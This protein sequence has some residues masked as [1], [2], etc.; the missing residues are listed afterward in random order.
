[1]RNV[2][3]FL[4]TVSLLGLPGFNRL[5][6]QTGAESETMKRM[7]AD[8]RLNGL[9]IEHSGTQDLGVLCPGK[10]MR[11]EVTDSIVTELGVKLF[12]E[13]MGRSDTPIYDFIERYLLALMLK[14]NRAEQDKRLRADSVILKVNGGNFAKSRL[15]VVNIVRSIESTSLFRLDG[16]DSRVRAQW[17]T[18]GGHIELSFPRQYD[19]ILGRDKKELANAFRTELEAFAG[20]DVPALSYTPLP[21]QYMPDRDIYADLGPTLLIPQIKS[22]RYLQYQP[23]EG[24]FVWLF[25]EWMTEESLLNLFGNADKMGRKNRL[26]MTVKSYRLFEEFPFSINRLCAYMRAR[27]CTAYMGAETETETELTGTVIYV[28]RDLMYLHLL[29]FKFPKEAFREENIPISATLHPYI[30]IHNIA[31]LFDDIKKGIE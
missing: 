27:N 11:V 13:T 3:P 6:S 22:G 24:R 16:D 25:N 17:Q 4:F 23:K 15:S 8:A 28:N 7:L 1:M 10:W 2:L 31:S 5:S 18:A 20:Q 26:Q 29:H 14:R 12:P 30:P 21:S 9:Q 19:L